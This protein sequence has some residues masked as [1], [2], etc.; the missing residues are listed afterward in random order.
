M[1]WPGI[2]QEIELLVHDSEAC[3]VNGKA[4]Q[5]LLPPLQA[6]Q[7]PATPWDHIQVDLCG[8]FHGAPAH[9]RY[10]VVVY[11]LYL[12]WSEAYSKSV[13]TSSLIR[14]QDDMFYHWGLPHFITTDNGS[15]FISANF[16]TYLQ[17]HGIKHTRTAV[18]H[19]QANGGVN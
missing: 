13:H 16:V 14:V 2:D 1:W 6:L 15:Q 7:W 5:L 9:Y 4:C 8:E 10:L 17:Q 11:D 19:L 3:L 18:C 12:K